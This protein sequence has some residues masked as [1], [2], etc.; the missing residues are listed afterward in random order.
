L[1]TI[2]RRKRYGLLGAALVATFGLLMGACD[3]EGDGG[4]PTDVTT[5]QP[6]QITDIIASPKS[7]D[8]G[9]TLLLSA[10][11]TS[12]SPN[13]GDVPSMEWT[14]TGGAFLEDD[15]TS[16]RW[17]APVSGVY[18]VTARARN[19]VSSA[20]NSADLF[21]G[22][23][24]TLVNNL[25]GAI[26][27]K[28]N[29]ADFYFLR[30]GSNIVTQG[31]DVY[32][33]I[34]GAASDAVTLPAATTGTNNRHV[35][36]APDLSFEVHASDSIIV[37]Q[38]TSPVNLYLGDFGTATYQRISS[39]VP[40]GDRHP[41]FGNPDV[42]PDN[43]S[44]AYGGML[45]TALAAGADTFDVFLYDRVGPTRRNLTVA[46]SNHRNAFPTWSTG[47]RWLAFVSDRSG[48]GQWDLYGMPVNVLGVINTA[49]ASLVRLSNTG[50]LL[51][52]GN[53]GDLAFVKPAL[54]WN[55]AVATLALQDVEGKL[56]LIIT[57]PAGAT[58]VEI[59][60]VNDFSWSPDGSLLALALPGVVAT[61]NS[62]GSGFAYR[63]GF[64]G[65]DFTRPDDI[66]DD[67]S[68]SP[69]GAWIVYR[70]SRSSSS[71]FEVYDL[72]QS[73]IT[74]PIA[75]TPAEPAAS[76]FWSLGA[77]RLLMPMKAAWGSAGQLYYPTFGTGAATVGIRSVD[78]S[79]LTP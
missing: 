20:T 73:T 50:G 79:G 45:P 68:W 26:R 52:A 66:F 25:A 47:Q 67:I 38:T 44:I 63:V 8:P 36:Y 16:V 1:K 78:V 48:R 75:L 12:T 11:V 76:T 21:V 54:E 28:A 70:A 7:A 64:D 29:G 49:Q 62:D 41:G 51:A 18:T 17:V 60:E 32:Q 34:A 65:V 43:H 77:Y 10:I 57:T 24:A 6:I 59:G 31:A 71:W 56:Y 72:D 61:V 40:I 4:S 14:A 5:S 9:D 39:G 22:G 13:P 19:T 2:D 35:A 27:L 53:P 58:Q 69:D 55:P 3:D 30:T 33:V 74:L 23:T 46:H 42:A 15:E 37:G